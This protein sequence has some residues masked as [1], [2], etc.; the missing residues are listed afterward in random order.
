[1]AAMAATPLS[2]RWRGHP[3]SAPDAGGVEEEDGGLAVDR[4]VDGGIEVSSGP[5]GEGDPGDDGDAADDDEASSGLFE[6]GND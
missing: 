3:G 6:R 1:M 2:V 4:R 5:L